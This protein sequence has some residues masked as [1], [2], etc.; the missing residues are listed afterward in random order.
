MPGDSSEI[1]SFGTA[2]SPDGRLLAAGGTGSVLR[3]WEPATGK[4]LYRTVGHQQPVLAVAFSPDGKL[5]ASA[6]ADKSVRLWDWANHR[7]VRPL[8]GH[9]GPVNFVGWSSDGKV[10]YSGSGSEGVLRAWDPATGKEL[11]RLDISSVAD[12]DLAQGMGVFAPITESAF[13]FAPAAGVVAGVGYKGDGKSSAIIATIWDAATGK[14]LRD[15]ELALPGNANTFMFQSMVGAPALALS[16]DGTM[17]A[18]SVGRKI[19][20]WDAGSGKRLRQFPASAGRVTSLSFA[21]DGKS[22]ALVHHDDPQPGAPPPEDSLPTDDTVTLRDTATGEELH[23]LDGHEGRIVAVSFAAD[24]KLLASVGSDQTVR[25]WDTA[26]G[27]QLRRTT[28]HL[29]GVSAAAFT[30]DGTTLATGSGDTTVL[31]WQV[32]DLLRAGGPRAAAP[33][34]E[35]LWV[36]WADLTSGDAGRAQ[37]AMQLLVTAPEQSVPFLRKH[38]QPS[39]KDAATAKQIAQ[40]I[41]DLE[42]AQFGTRQEATQKLEKAGEQAEA[43]LQQALAG[44]PPLEV[45]RRVEELLQRLEGQLTEG[46]ALRA[47]R[48]IE[49]LERIG[50][51]PAQQV[52]EGLAKG[53]PEARR[54]REARAALDR[55][56]RR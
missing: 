35:R 34:A 18:T 52:L 1:M 31:L 22:L 47:Q 40:W 24:G 16:P 17:L 49:V 43:A 20:L 42:S 36:S 48:A 25:V 9:D 14:Q 5:L 54:T 32:A 12:R 7:E 11:R 53:A 13:A 50:T 4:E 26:T 8:W 19:M 10:V 2:Y 56:A 28:G 55:L 41:A 30:P 44:K 3:F 21:P 45:Q 15:I 33:A 23:Q 6:G 39:P 37:Q 27:R 38:L 46:E 29:D 51:E